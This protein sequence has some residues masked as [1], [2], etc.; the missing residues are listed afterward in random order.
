MFH[1]KLITRVLQLSE[2]LDLRTWPTENRG[3]DRSNEY[4]SNARFTA[5]L[6]NLNAQL[7]SA[8]MQRESDANRPAAYLHPASEGQDACRG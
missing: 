8:A 6:H 2:E 3:P 7:T 5:E 1:T 4:D